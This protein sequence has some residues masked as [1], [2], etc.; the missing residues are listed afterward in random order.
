MFF[1]DVGGG[2][3]GK[4]DNHTES[5][6][7]QNAGWGRQGQ[8]RRRQSQVEGATIKPGGEAQHAPRAAPGA[9]AGEAAGEGPTQSTTVQDDGPAHNK[10]IGPD[11]HQNTGDSGDTVNHSF[12]ASDTSQWQSCKPLM[13]SKTGL[14]QRTR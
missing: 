8:G 9:T 1:P 12:N 4:T 5:I 7:V 11:K 2:A 3:V 13:V 6:S 14:H 10:H